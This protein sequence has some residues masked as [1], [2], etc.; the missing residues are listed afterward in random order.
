MS[1]Y[2]PI[3]I[4]GM[5]AINTGCVTERTDFDLNPVQFRKQKRI[6]VSMKHVQCFHLVTHFLVTASPEHRA[7]AQR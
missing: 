4:D 3:V 5:G 1:V 6:K 2:P 7:R